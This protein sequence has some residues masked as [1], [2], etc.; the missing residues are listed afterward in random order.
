MPSYTNTISEIKKFST[1]KEQ[2]NSLLALMDY[3]HTGYGVAMGKVATRDGFDCAMPA[4]FT[5]GIY[6]GD[7]TLADYITALIN[8]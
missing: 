3:Y 6:I 1:D 4:Y 7:Q 2:S 5:G 8:K